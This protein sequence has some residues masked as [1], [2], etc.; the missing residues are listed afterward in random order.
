[1]KH[2]KKWFINRIGKRIY[3]NA[4]TCTC[5]TCRRVYEKGL[6]VADKF[7]CDYL[8]MV[9]YDLDIDYQDKPLTN[10]NEKD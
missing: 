5:E 4:T 6:I 9:Q 2:T 1:M 7:H 10:Q 8:F 3:R